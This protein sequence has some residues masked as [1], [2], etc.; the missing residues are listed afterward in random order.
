VLAASPTDAGKQMLASDT[1]IRVGD[2]SIIGRVSATGEPRIMRNTSTDIF[3]ISNSL[4]PNTRSEIALPLKAENNVIG[5]LDLHSDTPNK[6]SDDDLSIFQILADQLAAAI[7]RTRLLQE[8]ERSLS[9]LETAY[10]QYTRENWKNVAES[11]L[12]GKV[13]YRFDNIR[14]ESVT[15][16]PEI[17][18]EALQKG[19]TVTT[20]GNGQQ[21]DKQ[22]YVAVPIKLRGHAIGVI[23]LKLKEGH[24]ED[25]IATVEQASER[26][27]S[28]FESARLY[29]EARLRA[30][31]EQ[32]ISLITS[33]ISSSSTYE[34]ILQTTVREI[35]TTLRDT[36][37]SIQILTDSKDTRQTG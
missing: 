14:L 2:L 25:T 18:K 31:R 17:G 26:L 24:P 20:T 8:V 4:L 30:D 36:E 21:Q 1:Q 6:F 28:A 29:E 37:V 22:S 12:K 5:V 19:A 35:G 27:A 13:G 3:L 11:T 9:E 23:S 10:G 16:L 15:E 7:E 32:S 33:A 34:E